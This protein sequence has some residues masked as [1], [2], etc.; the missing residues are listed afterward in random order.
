MLHLADRVP[1]LVSEI[2]CGGIPGDRPFE[3]QIFV[4]GSPI[5]SKKTALGIILAAILTLWI[6][7]PLTR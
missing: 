5:V 7:C 6:F 2:M 1:K 4:R 3:Q